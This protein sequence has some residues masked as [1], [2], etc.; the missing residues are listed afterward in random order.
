MATD[1]VRGSR[2]G[3]AHML[4]DGVS[5]CALG[6]REG[7]GIGGLSMFFTSY[8][9]LEGTSVAPRAHMGHALSPLEGHST[10]VLRCVS[11]QLRPPLSSQGHSG[12]CSIGGTD[13][14]HQDPAGCE[15]DAPSL[16]PRASFWGP[17]SPGAG[18]AWKEQFG[19]QREV[20]RTSADE[21]LSSGYF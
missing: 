17:G 20:G 15:D 18:V 21:T 3:A 8:S 14:G 12:L 9:G 10:C 4:S 13:S 1:V 19:V 6:Y 2:L 7:A 5:W 16:P 11:S